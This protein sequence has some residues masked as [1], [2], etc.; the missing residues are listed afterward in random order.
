VAE[1]SGTD[2]SKKLLLDEETGEMVSKNELKKRQKA[3]QK[4]KEKE[5][6]D[7]KKAEAAAA[8]AAAGGEDKKGKGAKLLGDDEELDPSKYTDNRRAYI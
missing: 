1:G 8:K 3:R 5:E 4:A 2:A 6:K 7:K